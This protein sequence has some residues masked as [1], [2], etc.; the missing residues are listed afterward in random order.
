MKEETIKTA[1]R[2]LLGISLVFAGIS[3]LTFDRKDF[4]AQV[5]NWLLLKEDDTV[6]HSGI[7]EI[8][9]R[10]ALALSPGHTE[11][12]M[13]KIAAF[14]VSVFSGNIPN[15]P[16]TLAR[17]ALIHPGEKLTPL[18]VSAD[19]DFWDSEKYTL[20][21]LKFIYKKYIL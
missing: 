19:A 11:K 15:I 6:L 17:S 5:P 13:G 9:L 7:A 2:V 4:R 16:M 18:A 21:K 8:V 20:M 12:A 14:F 3:R 1:A 10:S